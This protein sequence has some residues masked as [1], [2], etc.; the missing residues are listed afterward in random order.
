ML[1]RVWP[2]AEAVYICSE[3]V[4]DRKSFLLRRCQED[5]V[6]L[7]TVTSSQIEKSWDQ[8]A[9]WNASAGAVII[10]GG[11]MLNY[12]GPGLLLGEFAILAHTQL[13]KNI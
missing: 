12:W 8:L 2:A 9:E 4:K 7:T 13:L 5:Q 10:G 6:H 11:A 1:A 3:L